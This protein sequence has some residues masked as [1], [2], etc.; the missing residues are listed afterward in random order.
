M[1]VHRC[2]L[3]PALPFSAAISSTTA[4]RLSPTRGP[5]PFS[6]AG[7]H[8]PPGRAKHVVED[9]TLEPA[10]KESPRELSI[11]ALP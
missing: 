3:P 7:P 5:D 9:Q 6:C 11:A 1:G 2:A 4:C 10:R 8:R